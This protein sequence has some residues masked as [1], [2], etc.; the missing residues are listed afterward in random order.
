MSE[1]KQLSEQRNQLISDAKL[2]FTEFKQRQNNLTTIENQI[3][4]R[5]K[6]LQALRTSVERD[7]NALRKT[8]ENYEL[9]KERMLAVQR[10]RK[11]VL[12]EDIV[13]APKAAETLKAKPRADPIEVPKDETVERPLPPKRVGFTLKFESEEA[14]NRLLEKK[15]IRF[16]VFLG[17]K[18]WRVRLQKEIPEFVSVSKPQQYQEMDPAT[19]P[20]LYAT[21]FKRT[22]A[23]HGRHFEIWGVILPKSI[24]RSIQL[25]IRNK[26][27]GDVVINGQG[28]IRLENSNP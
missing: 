27:G 1:L 22:V 11:K 24:S 9:L 20:A 15:L 12:V 13:A 16:Y 25:K 4:N 5:K 6:S 7:R 2:S 26:Q 21:Y 14:F 8:Q 10:E 28:G 17:A 19:V 23:S 18:T 3:K